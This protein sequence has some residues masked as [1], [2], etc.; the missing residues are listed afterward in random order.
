[1]PLSPD[2][3]Q[4]LELNRLVNALMQA[5]FESLVFTLSVPQSVIPPGAAAQGNRSGSLLQW[6][7]GPTGCGMDAFLS[8]LGEIVPLTSDIKASAQEIKRRE[9]KTA[10]PYRGLEPFTSENKANFFGR[11]RWI[12]NLVTLL[13]Q[14]NSLLLHGPSGSG[15]SRASA[16][17]KGQNVLLLG[18]TLQDFHHIVW[19]H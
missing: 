5:D 17:K 4:R 9:L 16:R 2:Q 7:E 8:V 3:R 11:S 1:M 14:H 12:Q 13:N 6:V 19:L 10:S 15:K 18:G